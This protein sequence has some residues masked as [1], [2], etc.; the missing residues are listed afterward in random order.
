MDSAY[1]HY[2]KEQYGQDLTRGFWPNGSK[3]NDPNKFISHPGY[4]PMTRRLTAIAII[5][6]VS[7][8]N[9]QGL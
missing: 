1:L 3:D 7:G 2:H 6:A 9:L 8:F 5:A 4:N